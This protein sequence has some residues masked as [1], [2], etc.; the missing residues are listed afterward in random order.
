M[1]N[2]LRH[3]AISNG[4]L[5]VATFIIA[6]MSFEIFLR[7][8]MPIYLMAAPE[9]YEYDAELG[10]RHRSDIHIFNTTDY[11]E[12]V[13]I[14][15]LGAANFQE[16]FS[17]YKSLIFTIGDSFTRGVGVPADMSYPAQL[18]LVLNQDEHGFY[19]GQYGVVNLGVGG[20]GGE[21][22][23]LTLN[24]WSTLIRSP[25]IILYM[26]CDND[27]EDDQLFKSAYRHSHLVANNPSWGWMVKPMQW[28]TNNLQIILRTKL[29]LTEWRKSSIN[30]AIEN[31]IVAELESPVLDRLVRYAFEHGS[32]LIVSWS[33]PGNSYQWL[34]S[35]SSSHGIAF[36]DWV[37]K[38]ESVRSF[39]PMLPIDNEHS[40]KHHR[41]WVNRLIAEEYARQIR[42]AINN[43]KTY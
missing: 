13:K 35:W 29:L 18:D 11:Q 5:A 37:P 7:I 21:Q 22:N 42:V 39:I 12:E 8:F 27:F 23:L 43:I 16:N 6:L 17:R 4:V 24:R 9:A 14:N 10:L 26:G 20:Y 31:Q 30:K 19:S 36:A 40:G 34:K 25:D 1:K 38:V 33:D 15:Q 2:R 41:G 28:L 32:V 3:P